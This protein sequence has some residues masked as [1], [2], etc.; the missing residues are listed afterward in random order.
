MLPPSSFSL[1]LLVGRGASRGLSP[2]QLGLCWPSDLESVA[3][4][5]LERLNF[6][7]GSPFSRPG[8]SQGARRS[9]LPQQALEGPRA[10][11]PCVPPPPASGLGLLCL[12]V[13]ELR[14]V[15]KLNYPG[16]WTDSA[17][18]R[19]RPKEDVLRLESQLEANAA[20]SCEAVSVP[21][22]VT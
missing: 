8:C 12:W 4:V 1:L 19:P 15:Q 18:W 14:L 21:E 20:L 5:Y 2:G 13:R 9:H 6:T 7:A 22:A 17:G 11:S 3:L 16:A 10:R